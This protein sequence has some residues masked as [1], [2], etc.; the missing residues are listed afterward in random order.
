MDLRLLNGRQ[1]PG[2]PADDWV[3]KG[4]VLHEVHSVQQK[5][6]DVTTIGFV[7]VEAAERARVL[8]GW[9]LWEPGTLEVRWHNDLIETRDPGGNC[10][11]YGDMIFV[12]RSAAEEIGEISQCMIEAKRALEKAIFQ[13]EQKP[14]SL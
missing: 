4:L 1:R 8:T 12:H 6:K 2:E 9:E 13:L 7:A 10:R 11:Y 3:F 5:Y 14:N